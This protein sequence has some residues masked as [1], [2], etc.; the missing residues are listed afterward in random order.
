MQSA[1]ASM[2][3]QIWKEGK[4]EIKCFSRGSFG[5]W[6]NKSL[7]NRKVS[8]HLPFSPGLLP[9][10]LVLLMPTFLIHYRQL[11][12]FNFFGL[13]N[14]AYKLI[15]MKSG[16]KKSQSRG[17]YVH[18]LVHLWSNRQERIQDPEQGYESAAS[19][20]GLLLAVPGQHHNHC[21]FLILSSLLL[22][23]ISHH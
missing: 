8:M 7:E 11:G 13:C 12:F 9:S 16:T 19:H 22:I 14:D 6:M 20:F 17:F 4:A 23:F 10:F 18:Q 5:R 3:H 1:A 15:C 2:W 21:G